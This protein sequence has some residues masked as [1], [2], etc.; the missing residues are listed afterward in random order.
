M[1]GQYYWKENSMVV[2]L[3]DKRLNCNLLNGNVKCEKRMPVSLTVFL[4]LILMVY[5]GG[6]IC[7]SSLEVK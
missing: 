6:Q 1:V 5:F 7:S 3:R 4:K 2:T